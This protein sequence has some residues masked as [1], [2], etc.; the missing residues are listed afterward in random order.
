[1]AGF[2][3]PAEYRVAKATLDAMNK[4]IDNAPMSAKPVFKGIA[5]LHDLVQIYERAHLKPRPAM[6]AL[7]AGM[8]FIDGE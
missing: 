3:T 6:R 2:P 5:E 1:M 8:Q 7:G 4:E